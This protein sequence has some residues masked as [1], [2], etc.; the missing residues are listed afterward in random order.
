MNPAKTKLK[1]VLAIV[2][3]ASTSAW[4]GERISKSEAAS[5]TFLGALSVY[6]TKCADFTDFGYE[7]YKAAYQDQL[8]KGRNM[9]SMKEFI[10]G[11]KLANNDLSKGRSLGCSILRQV[12]LSEPI[13]RRF[14]N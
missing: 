12:I 10:Y 5:M 4:A 11:I 1:L 3:I 8:R 14:I 7:T 9:Y 6:E 2:L 13:F